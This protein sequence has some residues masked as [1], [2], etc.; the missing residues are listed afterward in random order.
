MQSHAWLRDLHAGLREVAADLASLWRRGL[1]AA[2][3]SGEAQVQRG[4]AC[5]QFRTLIQQFAANLVATAVAVVLWV[6]VLWAYSPG[7]AV[8]A[9]SIAALSCIVVQYR[10]GKRFL[11]AM[12]PDDALPGW[13]ARFCRGLFA[14]GTVWGG[15]VFTVPHH[16]A[17]LTPYLAIGLL[18]VL[19]GALS[20]F[21]AYRPGIA[22]F[23]VPCGLLSC[24]AL[25]SIG[26]LLNMALGI[27]FL[28]GVA[29]LMRLAYLQNTMMTQAMVSADERLVLLHELEARRREAEQA[30]QAKTRFL[31]SVSHDLRQPMHSIALLSGALRQHVAVDAAADAL[32][33][34]GSSVQAMDD[35][36]G[37]LLEVSRL[38]DGRLPLQVA[39]VALDP[40]FKRLELQFAAQARAKGLDLQVVASPAWVVSDAFQL[41]RMLAN[42][43]ANAIRY[44][45][46]G[47]VRLRCRVRGNEACLQVWD[48]GVGIA[49][50]HQVRVFE[51]FYQ[52]ARTP[53]EGAEGLGLGLAIVHRLG[54]RL[55]HRLTLRSRLQ[56]GSVFGVVVPLHTAHATQAPPGASLADLLATQLVLL[57]DDEAAARKGMQ[58]LLE[59]FGCHVL[60]AHSTQAALQRVDESLRTPDLI[61]TD[62][63]L[64]P[65]DTGLQAIAQVR[66]TVGEAIPALMVTAEVD[67]P[68]AA[69]RAL[70]VPVLP[71]PLQMD[72]LAVELRRLLQAQES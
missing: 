51:E 8:L 35:M 14:M 55:G 36:L 66:G 5:R 32:V 9:W 7:P 18:L 67:R 45:P 20:L 49:R 22:V 41:H 24:V 30:N 48:S 37:A 60:A 4:I 50:E 33:Q 2:P 28:V 19:T 38:D 71:K 17:E 11:R 21:V 46:R 31:A 25:V 72:A 54:Q 53:R 64:G 70:G 44:T 47:R 59:S 65:A 29:L 43:L 39:P 15:V 26:G 52:V 56:Q 1:P 6:I 57:I 58:L 3:L 68:I 63:R 12:P 13:E 16:A 62:Y 27:G 10:F 34:I 23:A 40:L 69:A 42:L 61:I